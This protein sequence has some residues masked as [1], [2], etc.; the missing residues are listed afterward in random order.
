MKLKR[1]NTLLEKQEDWGED[2]YDEYNDDELYGRPEY[3]KSIHS[4]TDD[5][6]NKDNGSLDDD[7]ENLYYLLRTYLKQKGIEAEIENKG[8]DL[9]IYVVLNKKEKLKSILNVF[10]AMKDMKNQILQQYESEFEMWETKTKDPMLTFMFSFD[11][12]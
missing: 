1:Y 11:G 8:L 3:K 9:T 2:G 12:K 7:M 4:Y 5:E 6:Y 10:S